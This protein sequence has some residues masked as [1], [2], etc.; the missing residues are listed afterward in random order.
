MLTAVSLVI[1]L[2][3]LTDAL[4]NRMVGGMLDDGLG[5][6]L[7]PARYRKIYRRLDNYGQRIY[8]IDLS[9]RAVRQFH[10]LSRKWIVGVSLKTVRVTANLLGIGR[11]MDFVYE[12][13]NA[14]RKIGMIDFFV[15]T[16]ERREKAWHDS[17]WD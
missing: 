7:D 11:V 12:G 9:G 3:E 16:I 14:F 10:R 13:Y 8:Q 2:H 1:E 15:E 5:P 4:D 6:A 17:L